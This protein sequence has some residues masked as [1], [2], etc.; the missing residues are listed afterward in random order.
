VKRVISKCAPDV[1]KEFKALE[2]IGINFYCTI[3]VKSN[4][5]VG[6]LMNNL[7]HQLHSTAVVVNIFSL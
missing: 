2:A 6:V 7:S 1:V 5:T 3:A 4:C